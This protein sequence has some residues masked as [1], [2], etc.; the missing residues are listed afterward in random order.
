MIEAGAKRGEFVRAKKS[1]MAD[2]GSH[3][4]DYQCGWPDCGVG[5]AECLQR[6]GPAEEQSCGHLL[7]FAQCGR[8][9]VRVF[10]SG[11]DFVFDLDHSEHQFESASEQLYRRGDA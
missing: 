5:L 4:D 10:A 6:F 1:E 11:C 3:S 7:D 2:L 9:F 8:D